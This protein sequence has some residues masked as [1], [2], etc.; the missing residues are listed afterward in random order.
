[1][2]EMEGGAEVEDDAGRCREVEG[3]GGRRR[4]VRWRA[5]KLLVAA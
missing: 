2:S 4:E 1:M 5:G 3:G